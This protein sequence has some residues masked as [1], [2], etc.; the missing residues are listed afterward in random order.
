MMQSIERMTGGRV[1]LGAGT[2]YGAIETLLKKGWILPAGDGGKKKY[3]LSQE[4]RGIAEA[5]AKRLRELE[6]LARS[7][8]GDE[9]E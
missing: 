9:S 2:L 5:E 7:I 1:V 3:V 4:G 8:L 6:K